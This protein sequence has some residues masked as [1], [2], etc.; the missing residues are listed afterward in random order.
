MPQPLFPGG[1][2]E[3]GTAPCIIE[4]GVDHANRQ[5]DGGDQKQPILSV[6][7]ATGRSLGFETHKRYLT[8][9]G[10]DGYLRLVPI[11]DK[12]NIFHRERLI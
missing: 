11:L 10:S 5:Q 12:N 1:G 3:L 6:G 9:K 2:L 8:S 7:D 4:N